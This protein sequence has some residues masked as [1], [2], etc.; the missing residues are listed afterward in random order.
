VSGRDLPI[1]GI[2]ESVG[3]YINTLPLVIHWGNDNTILSQLH[4]IQ[5]QVTELNTP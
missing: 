4:R 1:E 2:E 5:E 3:L